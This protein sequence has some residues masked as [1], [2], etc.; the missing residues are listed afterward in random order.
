MSDW[1]AHKALAANL[2]ALQASKGWSAPELQKKSEIGR[3]TVN[4]ILNQAVSA[5]LLSVQTMA[6]AFG[7]PAWA[8]LVPN[9]D[10]TVKGGDLENLVSRFLAA[11][12]DGRTA[13]LRLALAESTFSKH[14]GQD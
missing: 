4:N 12:P 1:D 6:K 5:R 7:L 2:R 10:V 13:I 3:S 14:P 8:L 11:S 9:L